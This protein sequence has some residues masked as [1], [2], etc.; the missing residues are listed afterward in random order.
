MNETITIQEAIHEYLIAIQE[1]N[2]SE[3]FTNTARRSLKRVEAFFG[4]DFLVKNLNPSNI[5][6]FYY[7]SEFI[8]LPTG[9]Q[10]RKRTLFAFSRAIVQFRR[11]MTEMNY[12]SAD[13]AP[14]MLF[15]P[16]LKGE[17]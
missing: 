5:Q 6:D 9:K 16:R 11:W 1:Q 15:F 7:S 13:Q 12:F 4:P 3:K 14:E 10:R 8:K 2:K 17:Y